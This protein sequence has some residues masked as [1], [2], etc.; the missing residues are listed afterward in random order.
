LTIFFSLFFPFGS[1]S[2]SAES[3]KIGQKRESVF[4]TTAEIE[5]LIGA[6][7]PLFDLTEKLM[8]LEN[9]EGR[10]RFT[11]R[12]LAVAT[13]T[14]LV[15]RL[16]EKLGVSPKKV[17]PPGRLLSPGELIWEGE[18]KGV[19]RLWKVAQNLFEYGMGVATYTRQMVE[20]G[21]QINPHLEIL[22]T[23][24]VIPYTKKVALEAVIDGGG[25]PHRVTTT[26]TILVFQNY[27]NLFGG[28]EK[29]YREFP[30]LKKRG[31]EKKWVV[32]ASTFSDALR[33]IE[34]EVDVVQLDKLPPDE[35]AEVVKK[36]HRRGIKVLAAGGIRLENIA[37]YAQTGV[38][39]IVTTAPYFAP[40]ADVKVEI[41]PL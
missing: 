35:V 5:A 15:N 13:G 22:T 41:T 39:G 37:D 1:N 14:E 28:W 19:L 18:G 4:Y 12:K 2:F 3:G 17:A 10:I 6:D 33:L 9:F 25:M 29:F 40:S 24:K 36:A 11:T 32:E 38:D 8:G 30:L 16:G 21:H 20:R 31:V 7:V 23:R 27:I 26:E 34:L